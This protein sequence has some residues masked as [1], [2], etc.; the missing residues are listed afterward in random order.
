[1]DKKN[2]IE[3]LSKASP[4]AKNSKEY[5]SGVVYQVFKIIP[6]KFRKTISNVVFLGVLGILILNIFIPDPF[7]GIPEAGL[8][9]ML[10]LL[11]QYKQNNE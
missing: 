10:Y 3:V 5:H 4:E 11:W 6:E 7:L 8:A 2:S 9:Y 1:M